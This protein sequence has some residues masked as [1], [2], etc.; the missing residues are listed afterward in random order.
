MKK[1]KIITKS[2]KIVDYKLEAHKIFLSRH[3]SEDRLQSENLVII[4]MV[5]SILILSFI[6]LYVQHSIARSLQFIMIFFGV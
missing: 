5:N 3:L 2:K 1:I 6:T 4:S